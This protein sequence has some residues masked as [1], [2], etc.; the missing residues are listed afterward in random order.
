MLIASSGGTCVSAC[1]IE[2]IGN[3][4]SANSS[5]ISVMAVVQ[6]TRRRPG[7]HFDRAR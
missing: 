1:D 4:D 6:A 2:G 5:A 7:R 3:S